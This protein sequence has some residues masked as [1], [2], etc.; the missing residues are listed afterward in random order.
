MKVVLSSLVFPKAEVRS[1]KARISPVLRG[2]EKESV[3]LDGAEEVRRV[4]RKVP[5][6]T[7]GR[8][9]YKTGLCT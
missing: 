7:F 8:K 2:C 9:R 1:L 5:R 6:K 3:G 4:C